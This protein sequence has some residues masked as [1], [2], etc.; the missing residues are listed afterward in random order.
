MVGVVFQ[1]ERAYHIDG[2]LPLWEEGGRWE[3]SGT[4][5]QSM[6]AVHLEVLPEVNIPAP[7]LSVADRLTEWYRSVVRFTNQKALFRAA[8]A[9]PRTLHFVGSALTSGE[10]SDSVPAP[11]MSF[12][13]AAQVPWMRRSWRWP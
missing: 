8:R 3:R 4:T 2:E 11:H 13:L 7:G 5:R 9:M 10:V 12:G 1:V 6:A